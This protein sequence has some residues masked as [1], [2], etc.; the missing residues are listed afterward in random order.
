MPIYEYECPSCGH[1]F[2]VL[3]KISENPDGKC[4]CCD[5]QAK[6]LFHPVGIVFKGNGFYTT[7]YKQKNSQPGQEGKESS[8]DDGKG[9]TDTTKPTKKDDA[10]D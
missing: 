7:D 2:E 3:R 6:R 5:A 9:S 10:A 4:P 8:S 1:R